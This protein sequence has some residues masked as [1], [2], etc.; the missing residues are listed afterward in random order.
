[1]AQLLCCALS[2]RAQTPL[3][4][5]FLPDA[6]AT[7]K[8]RKLERALIEGV[9]DRNR[10][11]LL[12]AVAECEAAAPGMHGVSPTLLPPAKEVIDMIKI[13]EEIDD[14]VNTRDADGGAREPDASAHVVAPLA[15]ARVCEAWRGTSMPRHGA[16]PMSVECTAW[17]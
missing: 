13:E 1:M 11:G 9:K 12:E 17:L 5:L 2:P 15:P 4:A 7:L 10:D 14:G 6:L 16:A 8:R 3:D